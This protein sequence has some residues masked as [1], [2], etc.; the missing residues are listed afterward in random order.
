MMALSGLTKFRNLSA[1]IAP[2][3]VK[4]IARQDIREMAKSI[5]K[6]NA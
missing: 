2:T 1:A 6:G 5:W 4:K 3:P